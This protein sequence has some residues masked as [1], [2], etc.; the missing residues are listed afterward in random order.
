MPDPDLSPLR[1][2]IVGG[3]FSGALVA[4]HLLRAA[5]PVHIDL[6]DPRPAGRGLAY[7]TLWDD[8]LLNVPAV[9]MSAFGSEPLNFLNWLHANGKPTAPPDYF[10][11]R[12]LFGTYIQDLLQTAARE[13]APRNSR[14]RQHYTE[15]VALSHDGIQARIAL[16]NGERI[17]VDKVVI[18]TGNPAPR[19]L[20][21]AP[22]GYFGSPWLPGALAGIDPDREVLLIGAG[23]TAVDAFLALESQGHRG[24]IHFVSRR[25]KVPHAHTSYRPLHEPFA[26]PAKASARELLHAIRARVREAEQHGVD[27]RAVIDSLRNNTNDI[28]CSL[29]IVEQRRVLRHAKT[30]WDIHRHRMAP[31]IG[32]RV[33]AARFRGQLQVHA[34]RVQSLLEDEQNISA[35]ILQRNGQPMTLHVA[36]VISCTGADEDYRRVPNPL[37]QS[38]LN[39]ERIAPN[40]IGKGIQTDSHGA[41]IDA[42]GVTND[43]LLTLGPPRLGGLLETIAVPELRKQAEALASYL[44]AIVYEPVEVPLELYLA[45][46]I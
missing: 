24:R 22:G 5:R 13:S 19:K 39:T 9:R 27:W 30:W 42:D 37:I 20:P 35:Q 15:A 34:G 21:N 43:W 6:I 33:S 10:A 16:A 23:L 31:E 40:Y 45:A 4:I 46:G 44:S 18:A 25:G 36:R 17:T 41:V 3:G 2:A 14:F 8:H 7:S 1:V 29:G 28:W 32:A 11:P 26:P 12:K 38:L